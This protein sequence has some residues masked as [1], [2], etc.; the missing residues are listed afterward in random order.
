MLFR[1]G[2]AQIIE[3]V[4][5][6]DKERVTFDHDIK[7]NAKGYEYFCYMKLLAQKRAERR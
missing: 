4:G 6:Y 1:S 7:A 3:L 2:G 5:D